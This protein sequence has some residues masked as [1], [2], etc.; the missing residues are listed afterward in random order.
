M[1]TGKPSP[2]DSGTLKIRTGFFLDRKVLS[3]EL[4]QNCRRGSG[5]F[6]LPG[7]LVEKVRLEERTAHR[8]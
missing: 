4:G 1:G 2:G 6:S 7:S 8:G 3:R 5:A